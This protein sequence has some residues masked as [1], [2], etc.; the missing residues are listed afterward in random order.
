L[1]YLAVAICASVLL[2]VLLVLP[3]RW[4]NPL[5]TTFVLRDDDVASVWVYR[6][7]TS[8]DDI[9]PM[10]Q[11]AV[12]ASEDQRFPNHYGFDFS[13]LKK[14]IVQQG[15]PKRGA[16]TISQQLVKN[17][18]LWSGKSVFRK[19]IEAYMTIFVEVLL[20]KQRILELYLNVVEFGSG[21]YG[22]DQA[23]K[24]FFNKKP[25][26]LNRVDASLLAAVL[27]NPK[28]MLVNK[29][30]AYVY[31]RA[32]DIRFAMR[33]LGGVSYLRKIR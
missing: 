16:S 19:L 3:L 24:K 11:M 29:P 22:V 32:L 4:L 7:W 12:I 25:K 21:V 31:D 15:S 14:V 6:Q 20:P 10:M 9:S 17:L 23:S 26:H 8:I 2:A 33:R 30:S 5:T 13:E 1:K 18:Y 27:P 28:K